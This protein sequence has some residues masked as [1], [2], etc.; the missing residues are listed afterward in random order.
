MAYQTISVYST[1]L[2]HMIIPKNKQ[3][4]LAQKM[5][6][7][8]YDISHLLKIMMSDDLNITCKNIYVYD[9]LLLPHT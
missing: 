3:N 1:F 5:M 8:K 2:S 9:I 4:G 6:A 7:F